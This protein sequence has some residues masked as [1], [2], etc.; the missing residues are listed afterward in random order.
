[1]K[2]DGSSWKISGKPVCT[3]TDVDNNQGLKVDN[4][5]QLGAT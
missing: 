2:A 1:M 5:N 3:A 4:N